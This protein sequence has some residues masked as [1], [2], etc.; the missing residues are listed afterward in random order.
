MQCKK[1]SCVI[2]TL[3]E[4]KNILRCLES[5][6]DVCD[7]IIVIDSGS[8]DKTVE[9][10]EK[11][12]VKIIQQDFLGY[13]EQKNFAIDQASND[14]IL[15]LDADEALSEELIE[16]IKTVKCNWTHDGYEMSRITNYCGKWI[17]H[18]GWYPDRKIRLFHRQKARW[19]GGALH[20]ELTMN[21]GAK[22][23]RIKGDIL[24]YSYYTIDD[25]INQI[26]KFTKISSQELFEKGK[27]P[28]FIKLYCS[29]PI[30]FLR[31]YFW[32]LG[33]LDGYMGFRISLMSSFATYLKYARAKE[34]FDN[35]KEKDAKKSN[36]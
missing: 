27:K 29:A 6:T 17:K 5:I 18:C 13:T 31:D 20:E 15:S 26:N 2:I 33:I 3:N 4:E 8:T 16:S 19:L 24:H 35:K 12:E 14:Y 36:N 25:H 11:F 10:C 9:V 21:Q 32:E 28:S 7:E 22:F 34:H 30:K 23:K 1:I